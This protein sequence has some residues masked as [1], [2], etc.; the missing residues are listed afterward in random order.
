MN[1]FIVKF[2]Q[3]VNYLLQLL[4][5]NFIG[6]SFCIYIYS[7]FIS[8]VAFVTYSVLYFFFLSMPWR[9]IFLVVVADLVIIYRIKSEEKK[10]LNEYY[11]VYHLSLLIK[12]FVI[13]LSRIKTF[14]YQTMTVGFF[15]SVTCI[16]I[17]L[18][19]LGDMQPRVS[20]D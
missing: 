11:D 1:I 3:I 10:T 6:F 8:R 4:L 7:S 5:N 17:R 15:F 19:E 16:V 14:V 12:T 13:L 20:L 18:N 2:Y 9:S